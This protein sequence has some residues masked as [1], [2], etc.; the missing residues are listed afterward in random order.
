[1]KIWHYY[2]TMKISHYYYEN[3]K[4]KKYKIYPNFNEFVCQQLI[5][6]TNISIFD[7]LKKMVVH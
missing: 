1:M 7:N 3:I 6:L 5:L 2:S 4:Y